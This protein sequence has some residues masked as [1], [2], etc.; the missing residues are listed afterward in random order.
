MIDLSIRPS[1]ASDAPELSRL[2]VEVARER[3]FLT[4][5]DGY[6]DRQVADYRKFLIDNG[7]LQLV[8][9]S[10]APN[11]A[12]ILGW[13]DLCPI[14]CPTMPAVGRLGMGLSPTVRER[15]YGRR[16]LTSILNQAFDGGFQR[17]ELEVFASNARAIR[18]YDRLGFVVEGRRRQ[19][20]KIDDRREDLILMGL[21]AEEARLLSWR[22]LE[23]NASG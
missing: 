5:L 20:I 11:P 21:L 7:G 3:R 23:A 8:L 6:D 14:V 19:L 17:I 15:G 9:C 16:L 13:A 2:I 12:T 10:T 18:L 4:T 22:K 1:L